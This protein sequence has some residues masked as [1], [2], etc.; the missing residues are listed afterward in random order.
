MDSFCSLYLFKRKK[1]K[2]DGACLVWKERSTKLL[3][4]WFSLAGGG[5]ACGGSRQ[6][7]HNKVQLELLGELGKFSCVS[8]TDE[9]TT[10][11]KLL[12]LLRR[13][14]ILTWFSFR[15]SS[16]VFSLGEEI[17][18]RE[19]WSFSFVLFNW[20]QVKIARREQKQPHDPGLRSWNVTTC[21]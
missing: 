17:K 10:R 19:S 9:R 20:I 6:Q 1:K 2:N 12:P 8:S 16:W 11:D 18:I 14:C 13:R 7:E 3:Q 15:V 4:C 21:F 5:G